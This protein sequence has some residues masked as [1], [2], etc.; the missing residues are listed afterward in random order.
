[1]SLPGL[2][3]QK[4]H[5]THDNHCTQSTLMIGSGDEFLA[6]KKKCVSVRVEQGNS[7]TNSPPPPPPPL[8]FDLLSLMLCFLCFLS[9]VL[10]SPLRRRHVGS[11]VVCVPPPTTD[12]V[13]P[14]S[15]SYVLFNAVTY[16][17]VLYL[18]SAMQL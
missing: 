18:L 4:A 1:M 13:S 16:G 14:Q 5:A 7:Q 6:G 15:F 2:L 12:H 10:V 8:F 17:P 9:L 3:S 11:H